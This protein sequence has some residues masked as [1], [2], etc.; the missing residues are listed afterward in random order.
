[1]FPT[2]F[3]NVE[4]K[5]YPKTN[6]LSSKGILPKAGELA[7]EGLPKLLRLKRLS[8]LESYKPTYQKSRGCLYHGSI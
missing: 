4:V 5:M 8:P 2:D 1:V 7:L 3:T 6:T